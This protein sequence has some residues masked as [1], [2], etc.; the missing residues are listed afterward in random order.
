MSTT[1]PESL[2]DNLHK[3]SQRERRLDAQSRWPRTRLLAGILFNEVSHIRTFS[4]AAALTYKT[5]FS[6]L[7]IF[8]LSLLLLS[9]ISSA[10]GGTALD[11]TLE[12]F[13]FRQ[14]SLDKLQITRAENPATAYSPDSDDE[15][16]GP[17]VSAQALVAPVIKSTR[18]A[19]TNPATGLIAFAILLYGSISL[20]IVIEGS[21]NLIYGAVKPRSWPRRIMLYWCVLTLGPIGVAASI[22]LGR[23]AYQTASSIAGH[24]L[25]LPLNIIAGFF[26]S[27]ALVFTMYKLIPDT[28]VNW[29]SCLFGSFVAAV[30]WEFGKWGFGLYVRYTLTHSWYGSLALI[31]LFML[32][33][34]LTWCAILLG[35]QA[36]YVHQFFPLLR[37][38]FLFSRLGAT[39]IS[40]VHWILALGILLHQR[41]VAGKALHPNEAAESLMIPNETAGQLLEGLQLA[42][43]VHTTRHLQYALARPPESIS[44]HELLLAARA[45]CLAPPEITDDLPAASSYPVSPA[46]KELEQLEST[47]AKNR[48]LVDLARPPGVPPSAG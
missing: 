32:W 7:P 29:R 37:R 31:P 5:L 16:T 41:F 45:V 25:L 11:A 36:A 19:V 46:L 30:L 17:E 34:Y 2:S 42:G 27:W 26:L 18:E 14:F 3:Q 6:L 13:F 35:L 23:S 22:V 12:R 33:I 38:R 4:Q 39:M 24:W 15:D 8:V 9:T 48:T 20:M 47:W 1:S 28:R 43:I 10:G 44:A 40:D 21:F